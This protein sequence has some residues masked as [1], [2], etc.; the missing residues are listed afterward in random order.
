MDKRA[1]RSLARHNTFRLQVPCYCC[2]I[3]V[4]LAAIISL[5]TT[6]FNSTSLTSSGTLP[7]RLEVGLLSSLCTDVMYRRDTHLLH[8][9]PRQLIFFLMPLPLALKQ[10]PPLSPSLLAV[11]A[12]RLPQTPCTARR[13]AQ[14]S[15]STI[16]TP[17]RFSLEG[18][19]HNNNYPTCLWIKV[20]VTSQIG[21]K[22]GV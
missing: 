7:V 11:V 14:I 12:T 8:T 20:I 3:K 19:E 13:S 1:F 17:H 22:L 15:L 9:P 6:V 5:M 4:Q 18:R 2:Y 21:G 10:L 16:V